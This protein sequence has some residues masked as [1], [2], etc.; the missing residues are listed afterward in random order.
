MIDLTPAARRT[1]A[2]IAA[3]PDDL[4][5]A[6]TPCEKMS[7]T[8]LI[9]H[10]DGLSQAFT[11]AAEKSPEIE[12]GPPPSVQNADLGDDWR[13]RIPRRLEALAQAWRDPAAWE[14]MTK[15][16]GVDLPGEVAGLVALDEVLV[17]GWDIA[18]ALDRPYSVS[19][20][21]AE[22]CLEFVS[23]TPEDPEPGNGLF[24]PAVPVPAGAPALDRLIGR[25]G[26]DPFWTP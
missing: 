19:G 8:E 7:L 21:E 13:E 5:D 16:G 18:R 6:P 12:S 20:E 10:V 11:W 9:F 2:L 26:R 25:T 14:G 24:G 23:Q 17:H 3:V 15:A 4:L 22:A 1:A